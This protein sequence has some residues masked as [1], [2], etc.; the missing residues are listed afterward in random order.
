MLAKVYVSL[1]FDLSLTLGADYP[2]YGYEENGYQIMFEVPTRSEKPSNDFDLYVEQIN[3]KPAVQADVLVIVIHKASFDNKMDDEIDPPVPI[4]Q[5]A[6]DSFLARRKVR[7]Q[8]P[9]D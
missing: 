7:H 6:I 3:G 2:V 4:I 8:S 5:K 9:S 1:P